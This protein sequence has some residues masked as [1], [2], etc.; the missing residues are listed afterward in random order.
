ME[1]KSIDADAASVYVCLCVSVCVCPYVFDFQ[2]PAPMTEDLLEE[3]SE[4]LAKLGSSAE[5]THLRARM[6]SACLLSDMESFKVIQADLQTLSQYMGFIYQTAA[7]DWCPSLY[8]ICV[9]VFLQCLLLLSNF[10]KSKFFITDW[11]KNGSFDSK[12]CWTLG[13]CMIFQRKV[14]ATVCNSP[15]LK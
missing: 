11:G 3:Q 8:V 1:W 2:E 14:K 4:V 5:G 7:A 6:Q 10:Q 12:G 13:S 9:C 15:P